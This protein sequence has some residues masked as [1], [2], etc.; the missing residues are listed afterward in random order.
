MKKHFIILLALAMTSCETKPDGNGGN[1]GSGGIVATHKFLNIVQETSRTVQEVFMKAG[2]TPTVDSSGTSD[3]YRIPGILTLDDGRIAYTGDVRW[4][5]TSDSAHNIDS[6]IRFSDDNGKTWDDMRYVQQ[7]DDFSHENVLGSGSNV[8][9]LAMSASYID[10][11]IVQAPNGD[12]LV[13]TTVFPRGAGLF[14]NKTTGENRNNLFSPYIWDGGKTYL[15]LRPAKSSGSGTD[16]TYTHRVEIKSSGTAEITKLDGSGGTGIFM[17]AD[18]MLY[19]GGKN[20]EGPQ[21]KKGSK[22]SNMEEVSPKKLVHTHIFYYN[23]PWWPVPKSYIFMTRSTDGGKTWPKPK[24]ITHTFIEDSVFAISQFYGVSPGVG[25]RVR[26]GKYKNRLLVALQPVDAAGKACWTAAIYSD[27]DGKTWTAGNTVVAGSAGTTRMSETQ[28]VE[29]PEDQLFAFHRTGSP[30]GDVAYSVSKDG[31]VTWETAL[32]GLNSV[33]GG[34]VMIGATPL[35]QTTLFGQKMLALSLPWSGARESGAVFIG[36]FKKGATGTYV[37]TF[38][39]HPT[40]GTDDA[41]YRTYV[42]PQDENHKY[43]Y[44]SLTELPN[45]NIG[46]AYEYHNDPYGVAETAGRS[47]D[48]TEIKLNRE[49]IK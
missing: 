26:D 28:Y 44:S 24:D 16:A 21:Y 17:D 31:G 35:H 12:I 23:S 15:K 27:N 49:E 5:S 48:F 46:V 10:P 6:A 43:G 38:P 45:G 19:Q 32:T 13:L 36:Y 14:N 20:L 25:Y 4:A 18:W 8:S 22:A 37:P 30:A 47:L 1:S 9:V 3:A 40:T 39:G 42:T 33:K 41:A 34:G 11:G 7:F 29:G 2:K